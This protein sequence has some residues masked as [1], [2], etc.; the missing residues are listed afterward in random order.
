MAPRAL[1]GWVPGGTSPKRPKTVFRTKKT[2]NGDNTPYRLARS[3]VAFELQCFCNCT[4]SSFIQSYNVDTFCMSKY[5][6]RSISVIF[7][8]AILCEMS[9]NTVQDTEQCCSPCSCTAFLY[10]VYCVFASCY[11]LD[12]SYLACL[13]YTSPSPRDGL[14]SRMPSSA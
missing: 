10:V 13:L 1:H 14:L 8:T 7:R 6:A 5:N 11:I 2:E 12:I 4:L 3:W 9:Q